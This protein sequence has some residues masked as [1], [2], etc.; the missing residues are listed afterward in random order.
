MDRHIDKWKRIENPEINPYIYSPL[1]FFLHRCQ[2]NSMGE[3]T[4]F[5]TRVLG[6]LD[7][8]KKMNLYT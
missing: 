8:Y 6:Q 5:S 7:I 3:R 2:G 4:V 1:I